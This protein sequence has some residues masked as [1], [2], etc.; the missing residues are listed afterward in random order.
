MNLLC[1]NC[2][3]PLT[4]P[5]QYAGQLMR[6]PLC[7]G[8]FG[9]PSLAPPPAPPPPEPEIFRVAAEPPPKPPEPPP[10]P[11]AP[12]KRRPRA[13]EAAVPPPPPPTDYTHTVQLVLRPQALA[14][15]APAA[16]LLI[17]VLLF[18]PWV[19][20]YDLG[21]KEWYSQLGWGTG[22]GSE[23]SVLGAFYILLLFPT[24]A[25]ALAAAVVPLLSLKMPP[26]VEK[27]WAWRAAFV[28][29]VILLPTLLLLGELALGFGLER[30]VKDPGSVAEERAQAETFAGR[31]RA[32]TLNREVAQVTVGRTFWLDLAVLLQLLALVGAGLDAWMQYRSATRPPPRIDVMW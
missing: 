2:Q 32:S 30:L 22:F 8:T 9:V 28:A 4:V 23:W 14:W 10:A 17:F 19:A 7:N 11:Q 27:L 25:V 26:P 24:L 16:L 18:F 29:A 1:P 13:E 5:D 31:L 6:C 3:K 20:A 15:I 12:P 21:K